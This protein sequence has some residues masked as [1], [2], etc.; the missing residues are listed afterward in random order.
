MLEAILAVCFLVK[1]EYQADVSALTI[2]DEVRV[3][4]HARVSGI[5][6]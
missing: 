5:G 2:C 3:S 1:F 6:P 4:E